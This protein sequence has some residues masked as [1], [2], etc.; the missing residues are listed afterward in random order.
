MIHSSST[1]F[2]GFQMAWFNHFALI[3]VEYHGVFTHIYIYIY[4][5]ISLYI[6]IYTYIYISLS[7]YIYVY[8]YIYIYIYMYVYIYIYILSSIKPFPARFLRIPPSLLRVMD[9]DGFATCV[10]NI[11]IA[12]RKSPNN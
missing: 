9:L 2:D 8:I 3:H 11:A 12:R 1:W 5:Y 10:V 7:I 6:Y 4:I